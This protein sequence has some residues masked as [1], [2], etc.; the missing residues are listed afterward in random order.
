MQVIQL[1]STQMYAQSQF[2]LKSRVESVP[3]L[4]THSII[5]SLEE[6]RQING[7][8]TCAF[9]VH[10]ILLFWTPCVTMGTQKEKLFQ[11]T[12]KAKSLQIKTKYYFPVLT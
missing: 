5:R 11:P 2:L 1:N 7:Q 8:A 3:K 10:F 4:D 9:I 12:S 6:K